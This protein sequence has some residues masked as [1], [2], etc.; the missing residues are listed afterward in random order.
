MH[1]RKKQL[2]YVLMCH[3]KAAIFLKQQDHMNPHVLKNYPLHFIRICEKHV[4]VFNC[5]YKK[6]L[7]QGNQRFVVSLMCNLKV[8]G[9]VWVGVGSVM[10]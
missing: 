9:V 10:V 5:F 8:N 6:T 4:S 2:S 3:K 1:M 7:P